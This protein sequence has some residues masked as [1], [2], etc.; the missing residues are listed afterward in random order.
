MDE[1]LFISQERG[2]NDGNIR[3]WKYLM[4]GMK[5]ICD[6]QAHTERLSTIAMSVDNLWVF[7]SSHD[8]KLRMYS[9]ETMQLMRNVALGNNVI[10]ETTIEGQPAGIKISCCFPMPN[11]KTVLVGE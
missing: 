8:S 6:Y 1:K 4:T 2:V 11:N 5:M 3:Y 10:Q 9:M 7:S